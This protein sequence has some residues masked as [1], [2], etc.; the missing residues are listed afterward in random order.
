M[1]KIRKTGGGAEKAEKQESY[2]GD[3]F[4]M[5]TAMS[6]IAFGNG[7]EQAVNDAEALIEDI[8]SGTNVHRDDSEAG[9]LNASGGIAEASADLRELL[10]RGLTLSEASD[11]A[12]DLTIRP[13][14]ALWNIGGEDARLPSKGEIDTALK[15]VGYRN[16][17][18]VGSNIT[19]RN[20]AQID[21][22]GIAKGYASDRVAAL[23][24]ERG[25]EDALIVL[26]GNIY[27][28][29]KNEKGDDWQIGVRDPD[30][31]AGYI[32]VISARDESVVTSGAYERYSLLNGKKYGHIFDAKTGYPVESGLKSVTIISKDSALADAYST[33]LFVMGEDRALAFQREHSDE[34]DAVLITAGDRVICTPGVKD[35]FA[36]ND[37]SGK[38]LLQVSPTP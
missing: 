23:F 24:G 1:V 35:R 27:A 30:R 18:I 15:K 8:D 13:V 4:A 10:G 6:I 5:D 19:L 7:A 11:G 37:A 20:G 12:F 32:G 2:Q 33:A 16:V 9:G 14:S 28:L 38:Y 25:I 31:E 17:E 3:F 26:G 22:G 36:L 29:G 34:F 21:L